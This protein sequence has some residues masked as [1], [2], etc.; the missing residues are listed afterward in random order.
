MFQGSKHV[1]A[2]THFK[3]L[4]A[5]GASRHQ[6]HHRF[7]SHQLL[8]DG[9]VES[10]GAGALD[11]VRSHGLSARR[12]RRESA[13]QP[14]RRRPQR[15]P[16]E[17][18]EPAVRRC[19]RSALPG[20][21]SRR[22][23]VS[24][25]RHRFARRYRRRRSSATCSS[26]SGSTTRRTTPA[27]RSS[28]TSSPAPRASARREV[29]R[30][31]E[32]GPPT[33]RGSPRR[34]RRSPRRS[35]SPSPTRV[36]LPRVYI[37]WLTPAIYKPGDADADL[38]AEIL[39]GGKSSRLYKTLV[40][41]KQIAQAVS[42]EP[43]IADPRIEVH[44]R[45][46][47]PARPHGRGARDG[48]QRGAAP[49]RRRRARRQRARARPEHHRDAHHHRAR[50]A[51]RLRRQGRSPEQLRALPGQRRTICGRTSSATARATPQAVKAFATQYLQPTPRV[52][53]FARARREEARRADA[54][55]RRRRRR[56][57]APQS[58]NADEAWRKDM[59]KPGRSRRRSCRRRSSSRCPTA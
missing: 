21:V 23:S 56:P 55:G 58:V 4:E 28:A 33:C 6:R 16:A 22:A 8:R 37:A 14:A 2:D 17:R 29:L 3:L 44:D 31:P 27:W 40:Y 36:K 25:R 13:R 10:A 30:Q 18:R 1:A 19:R 12:A 38:A 5:A 41:D 7:R 57:A 35:G 20:A 48:D 9:A 59:P 51:R 11:R 50:N 26:S 47:G 52:V 32:A 15:A 39:G 34:R 53:L 46:D 54:A 45:S 49:L 42:G 43:G 24:R